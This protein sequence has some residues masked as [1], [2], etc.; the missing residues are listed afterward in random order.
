MNVYNADELVT[1]CV[2]Y[3]KG[4]LSGTEISTFEI[5]EEIAGKKHADLYDLTD[6]HFRVMEEAGKE[7]IMCDNSAYGDMLMG[8]PYSIPYIVSFNADRN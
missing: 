3:L 6:I 7:G 2:E 4:L 8:M 5:V 1:K